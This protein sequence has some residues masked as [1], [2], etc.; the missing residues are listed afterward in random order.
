M[1][2]AKGK[3]QVPHISEVGRPGFEMLGTLSQNLQQ[4]PIKYVSFLGTQYFHVETV[5]W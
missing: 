2:V 4:V 5:F 3:L 1:A